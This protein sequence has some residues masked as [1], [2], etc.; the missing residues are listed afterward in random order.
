[1]VKKELEES[2]S[3]D[4]EDLSLEEGSGSSDEDVSLS[5][6]EESEESVN[7]DEEDVLENEEE[8]YN[9]KEDIK[10]LDCMFDTDECL[11]E[12]DEVKEVLPLKDIKKLYKSVSSGIIELAFREF[13][14]KDK[15]WKKNSY[16][17]YLNPKYNITNKQYEYKENL[18]KLDDNDFYFY[19]CEST[20]EFNSYCEFLNN[21]YKEELKGSNVTVF[22]MD[23]SEYVQHLSYDF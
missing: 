7:E 19:I 18:E 6:E 12:E 16:E 10:K 8:E 3:S 17:I 2:E 15:K 4:E 23:K 5:E 14:Y 1:M 13:P 22:K 11:T 9:K 21:Q 20:S